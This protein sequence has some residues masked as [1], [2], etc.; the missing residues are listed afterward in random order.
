MH[1]NLYALSCFLFVAVACIDTDVDTDVDRA[2]TVSMETTPQA[3]A[4]PTPPGQASAGPGGAG[5]PFAST[6]TTQVTNPN[7]DLTYWVIEPRQWMGAGAQP[8]ALP[9]VVFLHGWSGNAPVWYDAWLTHLARKGN[10][11]IFPKFQN[12]TTWDQLFASNAAWS[13]RA[14]MTYLQQA[15]IR[16]LASYGMTL[17]GHSVGGVVAADLAHRWIA[18]GLPVPRALLL[19]MPLGNPF[20]LDPLTA[21]PPGTLINCV[22]ADEDTVVGRG[23]CDLIWSRTSHVV[24]RD[25]VFLRSDRRGSPALVAHHFTA[26]GT[27]ALAMRGLW[28]LAD[29]L[30]D[31]TLAGVNCAYAIGNTA[32]RRAMGEWSDGVAVRELAFGP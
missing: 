7:D 27:D 24:A 14:A 21:V 1:K 9:V 13:V 18:E 17:I 32:Q 3:I 31:C 26:N 22:V 16:P 10:L 25:F 20:T 6:A 11:V 29:G 4:L 12:L 23:G 15:Q 28:K 19:A 5:Y 30:R 2:D 8:Q